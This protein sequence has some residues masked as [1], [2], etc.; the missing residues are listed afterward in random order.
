MHRSISI[1]QQCKIDN[2]LRYYICK[3]NY[4]MFTFLDTVYAT[5]QNHLRATNNRFNLYSGGKQGKVSR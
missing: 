1:R 5:E 2:N 3:R 4:L